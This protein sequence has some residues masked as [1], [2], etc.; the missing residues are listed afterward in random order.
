MRIAFEVTAETEWGDS[1]GICGNRSDTGSWSPKDALTLATDPSTYPKWTGTLDVADGPCLFE[2]KAI[3]RRS[4]GDVEW[5]PLES[6]RKL[7]TAC[8]SLVHVA[9]RWGSAGVQITPE[10]AP[11]TPETRSTPPPPPAHGEDRDEVP[12]ANAPLG[13]QSRSLSWSGELRRSPLN[14]P[15]AGDVR[16]YDAAK[17]DLADR[18]QPLFTIPG[19]IDVSLPPSL[20]SSRSI[21]S[22]LGSSTRLDVPSSASLT[23]MLLTNAPLRG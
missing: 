12:L 6:N 8:F 11:R 5:E 4:T 17:R 14:S 10:M 22:S 15:P 21:G 2:F 19:S 9:C 7:I 18:H 3:R 20:G 16:W 23:D 13:P 1:I